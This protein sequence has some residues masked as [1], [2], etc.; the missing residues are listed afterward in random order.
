MKK[1]NDM[2]DAERIQALRQD[3][4][5]LFRAINVSDEEVCRLSTRLMKAETELADRRRREQ[6]GHDAT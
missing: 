5:V 3:I 4:D 2:T 1:W 6:F